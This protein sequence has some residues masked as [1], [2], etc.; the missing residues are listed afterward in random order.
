MPASPAQRCPQELVDY[1]NDVGAQHKPLAMANQRSWHQG[2][3]LSSKFMDQDVETHV[4][5]P[6]QK[7]LDEF[8]RIAK[9][10]EERNKRKKDYDYYRTKI[11]SLEQKRDK[12]KEEKLRRN[13]VK[14][15]QAKQIFQALTDESRTRMRD[16]IAE[17]FDFFGSPFCHLLATERAFLQGLHASME[18]FDQWTSDQGLRGAAE[19]MRGRPSRK[20]TP[21]TIDMILHNAGAGGDALGPPEHPGSLQR[22]SSGEG[23]GPY[24]AGRPYDGGPE[25]HNG[26]PSSVRLRQPRQGLGE[27]RGGGG[28]GRFEG[29]GKGWWRW[30]PSSRGPCCGLCAQV[31]VVPM[32]SMSSSAGGGRA[33]EGTAPNLMGADHAPQVRQESRDLISDAGPFGAGGAAASGGGGGGATLISFGDG[34]DA[35]PSGQPA[36]EAAAERYVALCDYVPQDSRMLSIRKGETLTKEKE[37]DGWFFGSN[38]E[39]KKGYFPCVPSRCPPPLFPTSPAP[40]TGLLGWGP[41]LTAGQTT[42]GK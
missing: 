28:G 39:G 15:S 34:A 31:P 36:L 25:P 27:R 10:W 24:H 37:E 20:R 18:P 41:H 29:E 23:T 13:E 4:I 6:I 17:R 35:P 19:R 40:L 26:Q 3:S 1:Y 5:T 30:P 32:D 8:D 38:A 22:S 33:P 12:D 16:I 42:A 11:T 2:S 21:Q 7:H 9:L 14:L